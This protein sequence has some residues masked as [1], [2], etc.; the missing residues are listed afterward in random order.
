[1][2]VE[3][4]AFMDID[5]VVGGDDQGVRVPR[6]ECQ[7]FMAIDAVVEGDDFMAAVLEGLDFMV[8]LPCIL[9]P[10]HAVGLVIGCEVG[11]ELLGREVGD[12]LLH[13]V[14]VGL[15]CEVGDPLLRHGAG[16]A[17][18]VVVVGGRAVVVGDHGAAIAVVRHRWFV[19]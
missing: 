19:V 9:V 3:G 17:V 5:A 15:G 13:P 10:G 6:L 7:D 11:E 2:V 4:E 12:P 18:G 1:M 14:V 16:H 8:S